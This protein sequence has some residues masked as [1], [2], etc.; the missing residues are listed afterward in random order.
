MRTS[1]RHSLA[2]LLLIALA[3]AATA[4]NK[5]FTNW[6]AGSSPQEIGKKIEDSKFATDLFHKVRD[7]MRRLRLAAPAINERGA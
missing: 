1:I 7:V 6:P 4:G 2:G 5:E 3:G